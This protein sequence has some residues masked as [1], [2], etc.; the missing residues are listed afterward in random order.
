MLFPQEEKEEQKLRKG[1]IFLKNAVSSYLC[2]ISLLFEA[3]VILRCF[4]VIEVILTFLNNFS[5]VAKSFIENYQHTSFSNIKF[6]KIYG[7]IFCV[8]IFCK[9][10]DWL[11]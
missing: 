10:N 7:P 5:G 8:Q 3:K 2:I 9:I 11:F 4:P 1:S 6:Q